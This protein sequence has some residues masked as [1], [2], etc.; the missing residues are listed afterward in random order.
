MIHTEYPICRPRE[1]SKRGKF[2]IKM[3]VVTGGNDNAIAIGL[4]VKQSQPENVDYE[5]SNNN[6]DEANE[7]E[8][9]NNMYVYKYHGR[10]GYI[11]SQTE[12]SKYFTEKIIR[13]QTYGTGDVITLHL[14]LA[15]RILTFLRNEK[16]VGE[17]RVSK[18][19]FAQN[20]L[21][22]FVSLN[23]PNSEV[24]VEFANG[25]SGNYLIFVSLSKWKKAYRFGTPIMLH[26][27]FYF[28]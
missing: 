15:T 4:R 27:F 22:P 26:I 7:D 2:T 25:F 8:S 19:A 10:N 20:N 9:N 13:S 18:K 11:Y 28:R 6:E 14:N 23:T 1:F 5:A 16:K 3:R 17:V 24:L 12:T 21:F